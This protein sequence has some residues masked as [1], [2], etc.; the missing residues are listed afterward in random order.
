MKINNFFGSSEAIDV[1]CSFCGLGQQ[2]KNPRQS[3][4]GKGG[5]GI[6]V[7]IDSVDNQADRSGSLADGQSYKFLTTEFRK[8]GINLYKDCWVTSCIKC[9]LEKVPTKKE[10]LQCNYKL[11]EEIEELAPKYIWTFGNIALGSITDKYYAGIQDVA[12]HG[13]IVPI[14]EHQAFFTPFYAIFMIQAKKKDPNFQ[15]VFIRDLK[16]AWRF[17]NKDAP[18]PNYDYANS[19]NITFLLDVD[20]VLN[21]L[22]ELI[23][24]GGEQTLDFETTGL[25]PHRV[26]HKIPTMAIATPAHCWAFPVDYQMYWKE[27][28]WYII[29]EKIAEYLNCKE[30]THVA[31]N[32]L[33][34]NLWS[35]VILEVA[36]FMDKCTMATQ[37][38][39]DHRKRTK[40]LKYQTFRRWGIHSYDKGSKRFISATHANDMNKMDEM[41]LPEQLLYVGRDAFLA[42]QLRLEQQKE[43][44]GRLKEADEF[45]QESV[46]TMSVLQMTGIRQDVEYFKKTEQELTDRIDGLE[47]AIQANEH[48]KRFV[49]RHRKAFN[50]SSPDDLKDLLFTQMEITSN[51]ETENKQ[52]SVDA[53]VLKELD[54]PITN[55]IL[56]SR[57]YLKLRDTYLA[58][59]K[60]EEVDG[61]M[62]PFFYLTTTVTYRSSSADP[63]FQNI[64][65]RDKEAKKVVRRG[66]IPRPGNMLAEIDF[67]GMEVS[68]S[69]TYHKDPNFIK[70]LTTPGTDMHRDNGSDIWQIP[71]EEITDEIRFFIK[72]GW[73]FP[74]FYG[75]WH[76]SCAPQLWETSRHL[77]I[78]SGIT[79]EEHLRELGIT[80]VEE[81]TEHCKTAED[82]LWNKRFKVY[83]Q[84][85]KD[86]NE[87]YLKNGYVETHMGFR[88]TDYMDRKQVANYP[89]QGTAFHLLLVCLNILV[90]KKKEYKWKS[91]IM[92]QVHDSGILDLFPEERD[93]ILSEFQRIVERDLPK[94]FSWINVPYRVD[95]ECSEIDGSFE[96]MSDYVF[97]N[98]ILVKK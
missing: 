89:I 66:I 73:T 71:G 75:D 13:D 14:Q 17:V 43:F 60:R 55:Y 64:P 54:L 41:P 32:K 84:W 30:V 83:S 2:C 86:I 92:G 62:Y 10:A 38:V 39:L 42:M 25:K 22:D 67:S 96:E 26:M 47:K 50:H 80:G 90:K 1:R 57:K 15:S 51:K 9:N 40:S 5:K 29:T 53:E 48:V 46:N 16:K 6:L 8:I 31:H 19:K 59:F 77:K 88:F 35:H 82:I 24:L 52:E 94:M 3:C 21:K 85:K 65:K 58:Q 4:V 36:E 97:K 76:G 78:V 34:E 37:H 7:V 33:F 63:N 20:D 49:K 11:M 95:F 70:Y 91:K 69:A 18:F 79:L 68:T 93:P 81:F 12:M 61:Y 56:D 74:Q 45:W 23:L 28:D 87:F 72:N 98:G 27:D 44:K